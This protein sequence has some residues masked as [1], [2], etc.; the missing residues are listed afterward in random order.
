MS[1]ISQQHNNQ[2]GNQALLLI[3]LA[4]FGLAFKGIAAKLAYASGINANYLLLVRFAAAL[5]LFWLGAR[6]I[7]G[8]F[9]HLTGRQWLHCAGAGFLYF[10]AAYT[11]FNALLYLDAGL[12]RLILFTYPVFVFMIIS[13]VERR[14]PIASQ[15]LAFVVIFSGL[16]IAIPV[17][18]IEQQNNFYLG[19]LF[20]LLASLTYGAYLAYSQKILANMP[21]GHFSTATSA[22]TLLLFALLIAFDNQEPALVYTWEGTWWSLFIAVF[23]TAVPFF[24]LYEGIKRC[25]ASTA[26]LITLAGPAITLLLAWWLL[27]EPLG[28]RQWAG[29]LILLGGVGLIDPKLSLWRLLRKRLSRQASSA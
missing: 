13:L 18:S 6:M 12:S 19:G 22:I 17:S 27:D 15:L 24:M 9:T 4:T 25:D 20:A 29:L 2:L 7:H 11:D 16:L 21:S 28:W 5:P 8:Q 26:S 3:A 14:R 1:S 23:C 10:L